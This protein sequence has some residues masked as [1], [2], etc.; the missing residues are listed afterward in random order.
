MIWV[1]LGKLTP[2]IDKTRE[3]FTS[4]G[5]GCSVFEMRDIEF[6]VEELGTGNL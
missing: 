1:F 2:I 6:E 5:C 3:C 4:C